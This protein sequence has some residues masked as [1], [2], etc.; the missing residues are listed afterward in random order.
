VHVFFERSSMVYANVFSSQ[1][2]AQ[3]KRQHEVL[4]WESIDHNLDIYNFS[5][6]KNR[7]IA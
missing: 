5:Q 1:H 3:A 4:P 6:K 2:H 7:S